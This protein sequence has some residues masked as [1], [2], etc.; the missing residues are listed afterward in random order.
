MLVWSAVYDISVFKWFLEFLIFYSKTQL[1]P[2]GFHQI[3]Q[4]LLFGNQ[5][6]VSIGCVQLPV[7]RLLDF[8]RFF[9]ES[10]YIATQFDNQNEIHQVLV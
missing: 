4:L 8:K 2:N 6:T 5:G 10:E 1:A 7:F 9:F 3:R